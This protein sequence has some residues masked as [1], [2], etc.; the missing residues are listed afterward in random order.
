MAELHDCFHTVCSIGLTL[1]TFLFLLAVW[2]FHVMFAEFKRVRRAH[3]LTHGAHGAQSIT[4]ALA[5]GTGAGVGNGTDGRSDAEAEMRRAPNTIK[6]L[7]RLAFHLLVTLC[8]LLQIP[9]YAVCV[10]EFYVPP[11]NATTGVRTPIACQG[12]NYTNWY[13]TRIVSQA[14]QFMAFTVVANEWLQ[15]VLAW[16]RAHQK[17]MDRDAAGRGGGGGGGAGVPSSPSSPSSSSRLGFGSVSSAVD[18]V[19]DTATEVSDAVTRAAGMAAKKATSLIGRYLALLNLVVVVVLGIVAFNSVIANNSESFFSGIVYRCVAAATA[20]LPVRAVDAIVVC[21]RRS[22]RHPLPILR[23]LP[24]APAPAS[25]HP[26]PDPLPA[27]ATEWYSARWRKWCWRCRFCS[28]AAACT[29][30]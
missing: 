12:Y 21:W 14:M 8:A 23:L 29:S 19:A 18:A 30:S 15:T 3:F 11:V 9:Y 20:R 7:G 5:L 28:V 6:V 16:E 24:S 1:F 17:Q 13:T 4:V 27:A 22:H 25:A 26:P 2:R 10:H